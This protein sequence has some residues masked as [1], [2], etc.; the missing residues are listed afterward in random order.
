MIR[1][2]QYD[3]YFKAVDGLH[4]SPSFRQLIVSLLA[5]NPAERPSIAQIRQSAFLQDASY[6]HERTRT[7][8]LAKVH[9]VIAMKQNAGK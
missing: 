2:R 3:D 9:G 8:L 7:M 4:L 5:Y 6:N 1:N